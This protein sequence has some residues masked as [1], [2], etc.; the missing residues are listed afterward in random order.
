MGSGFGATGPVDLTQGAMG[1]MAPSNSGEHKGHDQN[2]VN[3]YKNG[4]SEEDPKYINPAKETTQDEQKDNEKPKK[5]PGMLGQMFGPNQKEDKDVVDARKGLD[6][7]LKELGTSISGIIGEDGTI[8]TEK[9][10][11]VVN[12]KTD[13]LQAEKDKEIRKLESLKTKL[14]SEFNLTDVDKKLKELGYKSKTQIEEEFNSKSQSLQS[15]KQSLTENAESVKSAIMNRNISRTARSHN[16]N[17]FRKGITGMGNLARK[18]K[19]FRRR[20]YGGGGDGYVSDSD[21]G[22]RDQGSGG[23]A[24][25]QSGYLTD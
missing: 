22:W 11:A 12:K 9:L 20:G 17:V 15:K 19:G 18:A 6:S 14:G 23:L 10:N 16:G 1:D 24:S 21:G 25:S 13:K 5:N 2:S 7:S 8:D 4:E 3:K